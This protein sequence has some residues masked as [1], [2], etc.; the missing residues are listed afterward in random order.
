[1]RVLVLVCV[2]ACMRVVPVAADFGWADK[3]SDRFPQQNLGSIKHAVIRPP[4]VERAPQHAS[5]GYFSAHSHTKSWLQT[6]LLIRCYAMDR[7]P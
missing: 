4:Q 1:M 5:A 2:R 6:I 3:K 7:G